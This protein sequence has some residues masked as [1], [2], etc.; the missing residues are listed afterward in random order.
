MPRRGKLVGVGG[1][2]DGLVQR[3]EHFGGVGVGVLE[4]G[5]DGGVGL[6]QDGKLVGVGGLLM[7]SCSAASTLAASGSVSLSLA[8]TAA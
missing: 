8:A 5:G 1:F 3:G 2:A 7:A 6:R 4:F